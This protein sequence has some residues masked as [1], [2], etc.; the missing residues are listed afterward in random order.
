[1]LLSN[2]NEISNLPFRAYQ[3]CLAYQEHMDWMAAK[4]MMDVMELMVLW[5]LLDQEGQMGNRVPGVQ[6]VSLALVV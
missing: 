4:D 6:S 2:G 3:D 1:M 5:D